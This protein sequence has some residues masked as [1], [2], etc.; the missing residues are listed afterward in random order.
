[1]KARIKDTGEIVEIVSFLD[2]DEFPTTY[3]ED[4]LE[5][6]STKFDD[7]YW[8]KLRHQYAGMAMQGMLANGN[9]LDFRNDD[10]ERFLQNRRKLN[11]YALSERAVA[12]ANALINKLMEENTDNR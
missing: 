11:P 12:Y 1:M 6:G 3:D 8:E 9:Q 4:E 7:E 10:D 5:F 2:N